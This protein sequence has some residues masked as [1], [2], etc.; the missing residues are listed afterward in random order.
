M[1]ILFEQIK[2]EIQY[3]GYSPRTSET[4][5]KC[6]LKISNFFHKPLNEVTDDELNLFFHDP[7]TRKLSRSTQVL[8]I[9]SLNFLFANVLQRPLNLNVILPKKEIA[10]PNF[11]SREE[12]RI[13]LDRCHN[14]RCKTMITVCY[15]CG[16]RVGEVIHLRVCDI[17]GK[18]KT[19]YIERA[20]GNQ[21]RFVVASESVLVQLRHYWRA[22]HPTHWMFYSKWF[23]ER[24]ISSSSFTKQLNKLGKE[25]G[26]NKRCNPHALRHSF[27]THQLE[28]GMPLHQLQHQLGHQNIKTTETYLHWL[29]E[30][31]HGGADLLADRI[32]R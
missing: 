5:C 30:L 8:L 16:L 29:P 4:Y 20:K 14:L 3:R 9:N 11:L 6:L 10:P 13:L 26:L 31:G 21:S 28:A 19:L 24:P 1:N 12:I 7:A 25:C 22:Y 2:Q 15:G 32:E 27:A 23:P 17:D 18:R